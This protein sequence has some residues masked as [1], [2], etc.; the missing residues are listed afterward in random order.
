MATSNLSETNEEHHEAINSKIKIEVHEET[1]YPDRA[2]VKLKK[3]I[4]VEKVLKTPLNTPVHPDKVGK[5]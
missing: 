5:F 3:G 1:N 4:K 2:W